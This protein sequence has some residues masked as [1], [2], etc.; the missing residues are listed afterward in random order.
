M[1]GGPAMGISEDWPIVAACSNSLTLAGE[2]RCVIENIVGGEHPAQDH[3]VCELVATHPGPHHA[4]VQIAG[5][6]ETWLV[7]DSDGLRELRRHAACSLTIPLAQHGLQETTSCMLFDGHFG[8]HP[9][10]S[11]LWW[12]GDCD[13]RGFVPAQEAVTAHADQARAVDEAV[14]AY[15]A[16]IGHGVDAPTN[17]A[18]RRRKKL[19]AS[20]DSA[21]EALAAAVW[22]GGTSRAETDALRRRRD[23]AQRDLDELNE[24][25]SET[26]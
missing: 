8:P 14:G 9:C 19:I 26:E 2:E 10:G 17:I 16:V 3:A 18:T 24:C 25:H 23:T 11:G 22:H 7:W 15:A 5:D 6:Q 20:R 21:R 4:L 12:W 13:T 1:P